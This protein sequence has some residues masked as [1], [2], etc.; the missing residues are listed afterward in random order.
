M[1]YGF[2]CRYGGIGEFSGVDNLN[3]ARTIY[4]ANKLDKFQNAFTYPFGPR[5]KIIEV[6]EQGDKTAWLFMGGVALDT[7]HKIVSMMNRQK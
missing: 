1:V 6:I 3:P 7:V 5:D 2:R 4:V